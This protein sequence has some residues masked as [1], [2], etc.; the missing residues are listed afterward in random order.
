MER[1]RLNEVL[2]KLFSCY[3]VRSLLVQNYPK[4]LAVNQYFTVLHFNILKV[5]YC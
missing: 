4:V 2:L 1:A 3:A 5:A